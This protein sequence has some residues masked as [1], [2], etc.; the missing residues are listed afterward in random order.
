MSSTEIAN[1]DPGEGAPLMA[2][3]AAVGVP[4]SLAET[5][6]S[7]DPT[8]D[9]LDVIVEN[10]GGEFED[11]NLAKLPRM[12]F[13]TGGST[14]FDVPDASHPNGVRQERS[15]EGI[16]VLSQP[17]RAF[18]PTVN[19]TGNPPECFALDGKVGQGSFGVGSSANPTGK[20]VKCP[21]SAYGTKAQLEGAPPDAAGQACKQTRLLHILVPGSALPM[22][23][24]VPPASQKIADEYLMGLAASGTPTPFYA[25]EVELSL[26]RAGTT[27][28]Y[29][30]LVIRTKRR[31][32]PDEAKVTKIYARALKVMLASAGS[33]TLDAEMNAGGMGN[34]EDT[35][36]GIGFDDGEDATE[37]AQFDDVQGTDEEGYDQEAAST[38]ARKARTGAKA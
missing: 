32:D 26:Q 3:L 24:S 6:I 29:A 10:L 36:G 28:P 19:L 20:C 22:Q 38:G 35:G 25:V 16:L 18:W 11:L 23:L 4:D 8:S 1:T 33:S 21:M 12:K 7:L 17:R 37:D 2:R 30:E 15:L 9:V 13:P 34:A 14:N 27:N 31:L 5:Y